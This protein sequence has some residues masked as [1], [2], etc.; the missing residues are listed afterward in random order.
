M[1]SAG[2]WTE[3]EKSLENQIFYG[4]PNMNGKERHSLLLHQYSVLL[5]LSKKSLAGYPSYGGE[6]K[7]A[8]Q[9]RGE[10]GTRIHQLVKSGQVQVHTPYRISN[11]E[12]K[13]GSLKLNGELKGESYS[14]EGLDELI[15]NN[16]NVN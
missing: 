4:I 10:L 1:N 3:E 9:S 2:V 16:E 11:V 12:K 5:H 8:L 15:V 14:I 7:D 13:E 6:E